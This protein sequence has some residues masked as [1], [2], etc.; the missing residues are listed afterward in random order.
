MATIP[1]T[2]PLTNNPTNVSSKPPT[3]KKLTIILVTGISAPL[4]VVALAVV[5]I[6]IIAIIW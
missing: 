4:L 5:I 2:T 1:E 3:E 6:T